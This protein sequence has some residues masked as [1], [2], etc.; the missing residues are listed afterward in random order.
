[1]E[2]IELVARAAA[3]VSAQHVVKRARSD[4]ASVERV[5][6]LCDALDLE[7]NAAPAG[8]VMLGSA[9]SRLQLWAWDQP[10]LGGII[11]LRDNLEPE[12]RLF[13]IAHELGHYTL[14]RREGINLHPPRDQHEVSHRAAPH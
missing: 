4:I 3:A 2:R 8:D 14:H 12:T 13:A 1:M 6:R 5:E 10:E 9:Y 11:W 7:L